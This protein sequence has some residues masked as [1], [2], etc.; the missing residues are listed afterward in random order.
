MTKGIFDSHC[1]YDD[2]AFD[3][4]RYELLDRLLT[5]E[6]RP[7]DKMLHAAT[8][9]RSS[10]FGIETAKRYENY[11]TSIGFHPENVDNVPDD[12]MDLLGEL[13]E[14]AAAIHKLCAVGEIG[15]D[16]HYEGYNK[17]KQIQ[18]FKDQVRFAVRRS[19]PVIVHCRDATEDCMSILNEFRP[20]GVM[21]CFSGSAETA[22]E[23]VKLGMYIG[24]TGALAFA[25]NKKSRRAC[26]A[27]PIDRLLLETDCPYM[28][29]PPY[30]GRRS[31]SS[32]IAETAKVMAEI[33]GVSAAE[34]LRI[35]NEN[36]C[37]LFGIGSDGDTAFIG[38]Q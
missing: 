25:N 35:T 14:K 7:V 2:G 3:E 32:M 28:A 38:E 36:A 13:Y 20:E 10:L 8:D 15:L 37:R 16:Y 19:L 34:M 26:E 17:D 12:H 18:L 33:K 24:F 22:A 4:D 5:G 29:P 30:R 21:H 11:Y 27:V 6:D 1:H 31:D 23:V 9:E